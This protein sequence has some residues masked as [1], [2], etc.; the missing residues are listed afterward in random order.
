MSC[1]R[2]TGELETTPKNLGDDRKKNQ[3]N[4]EEFAAIDKTG[5]L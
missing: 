3:P 2:I 5:T 4:E 1:R